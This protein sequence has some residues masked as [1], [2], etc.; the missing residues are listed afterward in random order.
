MPEF[1]TVEINEA[2]A[3]CSGSGGPL[4]HPR[5]YLNLEPGGRAECPYCS[6]IFINKRLASH[7]VGHGGDGAAPAPGHH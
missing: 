4:G 6:R 7:G 2:V 3:A 1:E 5:V